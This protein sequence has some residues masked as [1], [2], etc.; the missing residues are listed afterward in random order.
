MKKILFSTF[1]FICMLGLTT[2]Y[3]QTDS[4]KLKIKKHKIKQTVK[5]SPRS[6]AAP[7]ARPQAPATTTVNV[8][9][10]PAPAPVEHS[11]TTT[12]ATTAPAR[13]AAP[14]ATVHTSASK[15]VHTSTVKH[16]A[17]RKAA[18]KHY[19]RTTVTTTSH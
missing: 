7:V 16:T 9:T 3:A 12:V 2:A 4:L 10:T 13:S 6:T 14:A 11:T 1:A 17:V 5:A 19:T 15:T 8:N 18:P